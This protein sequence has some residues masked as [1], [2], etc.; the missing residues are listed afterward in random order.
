MLKNLAVK[1]GCDKAPHG[2]CEMYEKYFHDIRYKKLRVLEIGVLNGNSLRLWREYFPNSYI[3]GIDINNCP[4]PENTDFKI[5]DM[6]VESNVKNFADNNGYWDIVIDDGGH[7]MQTQQL[8]IKYLWDK[9]KYGGYF[10][11]EDIHSSFMPAFK[12][13]NIEMSTY[14]LM[15]ALRDNKNFKSEYIDAGMLK[16][17]EGVEIYQR[18]PDLWTDSITSIVKKDDINNL[19]V[20][21]SAINI[22]CSVFNP[23]QRLD[24]LITTIQN[25]KYN[26]P[27]PIIVVLEASD[28]SFEYKSKILDCGVDDIMIKNS[29]NKYKSYGEL[30]LLLSFFNS[31]YINKYKH[32]KTVT[33]ISGRYWFTN[34]FD[35]YNFPIDMPV[36][37]E[38]AYATRTVY[39]VC[40]YR[41]PMT[42]IV[43]FTNKLIEINEKGI[44]YDL[45]ISFMEY[46]IFPKDI[47][48]CP[49]Y[50]GFAGLVGDK[51]IYGEM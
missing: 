10:V 16:D 42:N 48:Y 11:M 46:N 27:N 26:I 12:V 4:H 13:Q 21:T 6:S 40:F 17:I 20:I 36:F 41:F 51:G 34:K 30:N 2:Y 38:A 7:T 22:D 3:C 31:S 5:I 25:V 29:I 45:E 32:C 9:V 43:D 14:A 47:M 35:F 19:V 23:S 15:V 49:K 39:A 37:K 8:S 28:L 18:L 44:I 33:K 24:Q 1:Y 50:V